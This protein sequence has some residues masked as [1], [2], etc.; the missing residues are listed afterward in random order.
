MQWA[1]SIAGV[2]RNANQQDTGRIFRQDEQDFQDGESVG[3]CFHPIFDPSLQGALRK[4]A[5][6]PPK[7]ADSSNSTIPHPEN[8]VHPV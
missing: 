5:R 1:R 2:R 4:E 6:T 7:L 3:G 8:P